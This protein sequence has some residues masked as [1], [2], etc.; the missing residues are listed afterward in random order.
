MDTC[1]GRVPLSQLRI[2]RVR[3][4]D[5]VTVLIVSGEV[6]MTTGDQFRKALLRAL[7]EPDSHRLVLDLAGVWFLDSSAVS[8]LVTV[9]REAEE[10][11][12]TFGVVKADGGV[13]SV[14]EMLGVYRMLA[15]AE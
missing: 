10:R 7:D 6:D 1:S 13:R 8:C 3:H 14:L 9:R 5:G 2:D 4:A 12:L 15:L 11:G